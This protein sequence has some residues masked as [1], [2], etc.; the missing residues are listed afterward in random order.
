MAAQPA[1]LRARLAALDAQARTRAKRAEQEA[2]R[3]A[4]ALEVVAAPADRDPE[5]RNYNGDGPT[6]QEGGCRTMARPPTEPGTWGRV[7]TVGQVVTP[8][9]AWR[10]ARADER[11]QRYHARTYVRD[12]DGAL[13]QATAFDA[14]TATRKP[15]AAAA[16]RALRL[17]LRDRVEPRSGDAMRRDM[18][19]AEAGASWLVSVDRPDSRLADS[20]REQYR[21]AWQRY[22]RDS[23]FASFTLAQANRVPPIRSFLRTVADEHGAGAAKTTRTIISLVIGQAVAEGLFDVNAARQVPA[24]RRA[25]EVGPST[26]AR[27]Q[28]LRRAGVSDEAMARDTERAF[29]REQRDAIVALALY[30]DRARTADVADLIALLSVTGAR[31]SEALA[32]TWEDIDLSKGEGATAGVHLRGTKTEHADRTVHLPGWCADVMRRRVQLEGIAASGFVFPA[33]RTGQRRDRRN[34][35]RAIRGLLDRAGFPWA[36]PHTFRRTVATLL[37]AQGVGLATVANVLGHA[38]PS[39]TAREYLG[40]KSDTSAVAELL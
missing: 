13:R 16:E 35:A 34:T 26:S 32:L 25:S 30:D 36:S 14:G 6:G 27:A 1:R 17:K 20:T 33:P 3:N 29:T 8:D 2:R 37:D 7:T 39:M 15:S 38:D 12:L 11:P 23:P 5:P 19:F 40:R 31:I 22:L 4:L 28:R 18:T 21:A 24:P 9:G 10:K